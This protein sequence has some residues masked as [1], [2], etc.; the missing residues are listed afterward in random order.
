[1]ASVRL[2][3]TLLGVNATG[4]RVRRTRSA[5]AATARAAP[6]LL[7]VYPTAGPASTTPTAVATTVTAAASVSPPQEVRSTYPANVLRPQGAATISTS[8]AC[9]SAPSSTHSSFQSVLPCA[10]ITGLTLSAE[11]VPTIHRCAHR[12]DSQGRVLTRTAPFS[13]KPPPCGHSD[14]RGQGEGW[15]PISG[16]RP[17]FLALFTQVRGSRILRTSPLRRSMKLRQVLYPCIL[18]YVA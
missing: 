9:R 7:R 3:P 1:L 8:P 13:E 14:N 4:R 11:G 17:F 5:V 18:G 15:V 12:A 10:Q 6:A 2:L 16:V